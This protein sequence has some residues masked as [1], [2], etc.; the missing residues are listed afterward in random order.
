MLKVNY[1]QLRRGTDIDETI[2]CCLKTKIKGSNWPEAKILQWNFLSLVF[3]SLHLQKPT[4]WSH[5]L[6][7]PKCDLTHRPPGKV[8]VLSMANRYNL[9]HTNLFLRLVLYYWKTRLY[10]PKFLLAS[11]PTTNVNQNGSTRNNS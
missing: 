5:L 8:R 10:L 2:F 6:I 11:T 7:L 9:K 3:H 1:F 4:P